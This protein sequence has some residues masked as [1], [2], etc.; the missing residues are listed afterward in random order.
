MFSQGESG[1][2]HIRL[3][4][5]LP[6]VLLVCIALF[7]F[8]PHGVSAQESFTSDFQA[9]Q[10]LGSWCSQAINVSAQGGINLIMCS[11]G[12]VVTALLEIIVWALGLIILIVI[13]VLLV[14]AKYNGF[15]DASIVNAGW[16][17][18]RDL[19]NMF[20]IVI[21]LVSAFATIVD[22]DRGSFHYTKV[23]PKLLLMAVL[24]NFSKTIILFLVDF[25]Q[26]IMLTFVNAFQQS[27]AGNFVNGLG[28]T[29]V[30]SLPGQQAADT[31]GTAGGAA[32]TGGTTG[33]STGSGATSIINIIIALTLAAFLLSIMLATMLVLTIYLIARIVGIWIALIFAPAAFFATA[34]PDRLKKGLGTITDEYWGKLAG[35]LTG[36]P[37]I[38]F[39]L[40]LT[41]SSIQQAGDA[42]L[43]PALNFTSSNEAVSA[44]INSGIGNSQAIASFIV[45]ITLMLMGVSIAIKSS[46]TI[47]SSLGGLTTKVASTVQGLGARAAL[48]P[49]LGLARRAD[50]T[51]DITGRLGRGALRTPLLNRVLPVG[52]R[53]GLMRLGTM[54]RREAAA[55]A[56]KEAELTKHLTTEEQA[57]VVKTY[58]KGVLSTMSERR[59]AEQLI[60][61]VTTPAALKNRSK[62][63]MSALMK[64]KKFAR[65]PDQS[66]AKRLAGLQAGQEMQKATAAL[67]KEGKAVAEKSGDVEAVEKYEKILAEN[68]ALAG[69]ELGKTMAKMRDDPEKLKGLTKDAKQDVSVALEALPADTMQQ[70]GDKIVG[71]DQTKLDSFY[72]KNAGNKELVD[73]VKQAVSHV[74]DTAGGVTKQELESMRRVD[75]PGGKSALYGRE[76]NGAGAVVKGGGFERKRTGKQISTVEDLNTYLTANPANSN[77][78]LVSDALNAGV[79]LSRIA[80][81]GNAAQQGQTMNY[82]EAM[83]DTS[84]RDAAV[85]HDK[86]ALDAAL[87]TAMPALSQ[88]D[89]VD[90]DIQVKILSGVQQGGG[91]TTISTKW[92]MADFKQR[93]AMLKVMKQAVR[94]GA[95]IA[96][97]R[98]HGVGISTEEASVEQLVADLRNRFP[99]GRRGTPAAVRKILHEQT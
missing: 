63:R 86:A 6:F 84:M 55:E 20:F 41:L 13:E 65:M 44:I 73:T 46:A 4:K 51:F 54:R 98:S 81:M 25:S 66:E 76:V 31:A 47:S 27:A 57:S 38:A 59:K 40:W 97:K 22:Y 90:S 75:L 35:L 94:R 15:A 8:V 72:E 29:K 26:V 99:A 10:E 14:F 11:F 21:L 9:T 60:S 28:M 33:A 78:V 77:G 70:H 3:K 48:Y 64:E 92:D 89:D 71:F 50:R 83:S 82:L 80:K 7:L 62:T 93:E 5:A 2:F 53:Q 96:E 32:T 23:L 67:I 30:L 88:L 24:V 49:T 37:I 19:T 79:E 17:I 43:A 95:E 87:S 85:A 74:Q 58:G 36:G 39:F 52:A 45:G 69:N 42:G 56:G 34:L 91:A 61:Q 18:I 12:L 16:R 68:P 1:I